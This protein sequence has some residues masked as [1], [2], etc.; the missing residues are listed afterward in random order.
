MAN[1]ILSVDDSST[2]RRIVGRVVATLGMEMLEAGDGREAL[3]VLAAHAEDIALVVLDVNMP[4]LD[5]AATLQA[6]KK[7][8]RF[9]GI[10]VMMLTTES[11]RGRILEFIQAG[12]ANYLVK[13]FTPD[14]LAAKMAACLGDLF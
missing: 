8:P 11:E 4:E 6:M 2:I 3:A 5:G 9:Q 12:A 13:P 7:D 14:D 1:K 10:P